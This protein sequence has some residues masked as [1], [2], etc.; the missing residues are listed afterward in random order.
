VTGA[1]RQTV[2]TKARR[3]ASHSPDFKRKWT[4]LDGTALRG[5]R[6]SARPPG[7]K[8][9][10]RARFR[11]LA[12]RLLKGPP[13]GL[14]ALRSAIGLTAPSAIESRLANQLE[15]ALVRKWPSEEDRAR[16]FEN[17]CRSK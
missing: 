16:A 3:L 8:A 10:T 9:P 11:R 7:S 12:R 17:L 6:K 4:A 5:K 15:K 14:K 13:E 1:A 2:I